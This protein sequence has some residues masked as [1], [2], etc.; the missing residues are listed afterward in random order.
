MNE[1]KKVNTKTSKCNGVPHVASFIWTYAHIFNPLKQI[2]FSIEEE[3]TEF[4]HK[5][6]ETE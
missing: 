4:W 3:I 6:E 5:K 1:T 2:A